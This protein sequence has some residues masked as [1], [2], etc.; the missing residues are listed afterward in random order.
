[1]TILGHGRL[2]YDELEKGGKTITWK[3]D[4]HEAMMNIIGL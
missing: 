3:K 4:D 1:M 2:L